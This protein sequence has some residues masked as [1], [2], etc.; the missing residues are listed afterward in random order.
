MTLVSNDPSWWPVI[1][2]YHHYSYF[3]VV[4]STALAYDW[5]LSFGQELDLVW[6]QRWTFMTILYISVR[7]AGIVSS[8]LSMLLSFPGVSLT[9][10]ACNILYFI[11]LWMPFVAFC[12]LGVITITR[13]YAMYQ[14]SRKIL[15][16]LSVTLL[17]I[18]ATCGVLVVMIND[19][20]SVEEVILSGIHQ[21]FY[22]FEG[23]LELLMVVFWVL[24]AAWEVLALCLAVRI[25]IKHFREL[26][27]PSTGWTSEDSITVLIKYHM[28]YF[29]V[30]AILFCLHLGYLSPSVSGSY[31][32]G[33]QIYKGILQISLAQIFVLGP[34]LILS[35]RGYYA[36]RRMANSDTA[37][38]MITIIFEEQIRDSTG[39]GV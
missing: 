25:V 15:I 12:M 21:C 5:A 34:R 9:D 30:C 10:F 16:F 11:Q 6:R 2:W 32:S 38:T 35:I 33:S 37:T 13:I 39:G 3:L 23:N 17:V 31:S 29:A 18:V 28:F 27:Q 8:V 20:V 22:T 14:R 1:D 19:H 24:S 7:Y 36:K 26:Q 4:S